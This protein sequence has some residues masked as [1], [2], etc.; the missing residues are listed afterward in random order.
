VRRDANYKPSDLADAA[1]GLR[2]RRR[3]AGKA[4]GHGSL[5]EA[6]AVTGAVSGDIA[7]CVM[8]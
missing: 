7:G 8:L 1:S 4:A 5:S 3:G 2:E 6:E